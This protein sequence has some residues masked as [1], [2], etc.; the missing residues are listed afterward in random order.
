MYVT[1]G[2]YRASVINLNLESSANLY[3]GMVLK[4]T[5]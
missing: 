3:A 1:E 4:N 2:D 5:A